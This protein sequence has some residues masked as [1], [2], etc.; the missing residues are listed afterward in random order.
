MGKKYHTRSHIDA[1]I[2]LPGHAA[3]RTAAREQIR[4]LDNEWA[5]TAPAESGVCACGLRLSRSDVGGTCVH[6]R[7]EAFRLRMAERRETR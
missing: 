6:C 3:I 4:L 7:D 2:A 1:I 5:T